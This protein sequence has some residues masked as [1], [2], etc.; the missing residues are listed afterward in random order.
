MVEDTTRPIATSGLAF[1]YGSDLGGLRLHR[2]RSGWPAWPSQLGTR[3]AHALLI[4]GALQRIWGIANEA[5][6]SGIR[7]QFPHH[8]CH[9]F[10]C[11]LLVSIKR[12]SKS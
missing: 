11:S 9:R 2:S 7:G 12:I 6:R 5:D 1:G 8:S 4:G 10:H 3:N